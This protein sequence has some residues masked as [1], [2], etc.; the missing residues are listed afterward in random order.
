MNT[1]FKKCCVVGYGFIGAHL[2]RQLIRDGHQVVVIDR[3]SR[4]SDLDERVTWNQITF[5]DMQN[6]KQSVLGC[7]VVF[8]LVASSVPADTSVDLISELYQTVITTIKFVEICKSAGVKKIVFSSSASVYGDH[9]FNKVLETDP[10]NPISAHGIQKLTIEK[11]LLM[12]RKLGQ[13][14]T[15]I[16]RIA[17]PYGPGQSL[18]GRQGFVSIV[19]GNNMRGQATTIRGDGSAERDFIFIEDVVKAM[20]RFGVQSKGPGVLNLGS[21]V[22]ISLASLIKKIADLKI[23]NVDIQYLPAQDN[24]IKFSCLDTARINALGWRP[25]VSLHQGLEKTMK[26]HGII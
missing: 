22:S 4:P 10:T 1:P 9:G 23:Q 13:I 18:T 25:Q 2:E 17:N 12:A 3:K 7:D 20:A 26:Y 8:H 6:V 5:P 15:Q 21:G 14:D 19:L 24:E 16:F 11:H